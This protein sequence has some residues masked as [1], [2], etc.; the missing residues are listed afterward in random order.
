MTPSPSVGVDQRRERADRAVARRSRVAPRRKRRRARSTVSRPISTSASMTR[1]R[2]VDDRHA[3]AHVRARGCARCASARTCGEVDAVVDAERERRVGDGWAATVLPGGAQQ[4]AARRAGRARPGRCRSSSVLERVEQGAAVEG[5]DAGV[6]LADRELLLG[7]ASP[8]AL[9]STTRSTSPS[10]SRIDAAVAASGPRAPSSPSSRPRR[11][12]RGPSTSALIASAV[13]SGTSPLMT[14][15]GR[16]GVDV[17]ARGGDR[18]ARAPRAPAWTPSSTP[19]GRCA[20]SRRFGSSTTTTV[21]APAS[22]AAAIGHAISGR[23]Q[24]GCST[25]GSAERIRVP[26]PAARMTTVGAGTPRIVVSGRRADV[27][28]SLGSGVTG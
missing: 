10:A 12:P 18:V 1:A 5:V 20:S 24:S 8:G 11:S 9:V 6:D 14:T 7:V 23:P 3:G 2:R 28:R 17:L 4:R 15:H 27:R 16:A 19:S 22:R 21:P 26:S 13:I 25:F